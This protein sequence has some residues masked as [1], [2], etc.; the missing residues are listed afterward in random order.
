MIIK[1]NKELVYSSRIM[2]FVK[3]FA[4][5]ENGNFP[6]YESDKGKGQNAMSQIQSILHRIVCDS[7]REIPG[8]S[9][10]I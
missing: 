9:E 10:G 7:R 6:H 3:Q 5:F 2:Y 8:K 1:I 4:I